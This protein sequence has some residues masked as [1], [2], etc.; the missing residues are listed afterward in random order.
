MPYD[1][2]RN[3]QNVVVRLTTVLLYTR[4]SA[5]PH[6]RAVR[7][8]KDRNV[9]LATAVP[10]DRTG[11]ARKDRH[12]VFKSAALLCKVISVPH[13]RTG[14]ACKDRNVVFRLAVVL[15]TLDW[16]TT[17]VR[18]QIIFMPPPNQIC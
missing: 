10:H 7:T 18:K 2:T 1:R 6:D 4:V 3:D 12:V 5:V 8:R 11:R 13:D 17:N 14:H 9:V 15:D 16:K